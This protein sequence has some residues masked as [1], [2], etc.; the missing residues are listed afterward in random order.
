[1]FY[2]NLKKFLLMAP[3]ALAAF[4]GQ[5]AQAFAGW[6]VG[7]SVGGGHHH[8]DR[9][10]VRIPSHSTRYYYGGHSYYYYDGIYYSPARGGYMV[11]NPPPGIIVRGL[12]RGHHSVWVGNRRYYR[13]HDCY[14][15]RVRGGYRV[16][17]PPVIVQPAPVV[18]QPIGVEAPTVV[19]AAPGS[20]EEYSINVPDYNGGYKVVVIKRSGGGF[21]GPQG[22]FYN[23]FP[24][25]DHL[26][27]VYCHK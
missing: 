16:V 7:V 20:P 25:V 9:V 26:R 11:V 22:E 27:I 1:M 4:V 3:L 19:S 24:S 2:G 14:Y 5:P 21:V 15:E 8:R 10:V 12:P 17:R 18:Y 23:Q 6:S 13:H